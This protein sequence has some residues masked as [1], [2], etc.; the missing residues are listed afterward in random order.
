MKYFLA[1][2]LP[3]FLYANLAYESNYNK[4][5]AILES[6]NIDPSFIYDPMMNEMRETKSEAGA[7]QFFIKKMDDAAFL[8]PAI[9]DI[10]AK[11]KIP[12]E[13]LYLAMAESNFE[14]GASSAKRASGLWQF[15]PA[16]A[17]KFNLKIDQYV[18]ERQDFVK[19]TEAAS[20]YLTKLYGQFGKWYLAALAY[21]CGSGRLSKAIEKAGTDDLAVL[22]DQDEKYIPKESRLYIRKIVALSLIGNDEQFLLKNECEYLLNR[23]CAFPVSTIKV[24]H[25]ESLQRLSEIIDV[26][27]EDLQKLNRHLKQDFVPPSMNNYAIHIPYEKL[28]EFNQ[29]YTQAPIANSYKHHVVGK[30]DSLLFLSKKYGVSTK[31]IMEFNHLKTSALKIKQTLIMPVPNTQAFKKVPKKLFHTVQKGDSIVSIAKAHKV[32]IADIKE[33]NNLRTDMLKIGTKLE[34]YE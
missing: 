10:L 28:A 32:S 34:I 21:N 9:K 3:I 8:V 6:L 29:N 30:G 24:S 23:S 5:L 25:G 20:K 22:L 14:N 4:E 2:L 11:H 31:E 13:F 18:D 7:E 19:S 33:K 1:L 27:L 26:P 16:T 17:K 12:Q 15:M